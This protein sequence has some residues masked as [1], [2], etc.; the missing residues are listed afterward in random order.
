MTVI[1][2]LLITFFLLLRDPRVQTFLA[3]MASDYLSKALKTEIRIG[4]FDLSVFRGLIIEKIS[5]KDRYNQQ[6]ISADKISIIPGRFSYSKK[7]LNIQKIFLDKGVFQLVTHKGD[8][9]LSFQFIIDYFSSRTT[10]QKP[11]DTTPGTKWNLS[12][13]AVQIADTRFH[14]QDENAAPADT[15][16]DY[17]NIDINHINILIT[18]FI[19]YEDTLVGKIRYLSAVERSGFALRSFSGD[20]R[21]SSKFIRVK[22]L[23]IVTDRANLDLDL[24]F[25]Y[26]TWSDF[27][28]F[29]NKV[30]IRAE[31]NPSEIDLQ[32]I[33]HF[34][35][36]MYDMK[37]R[38][39][40]RG[41]VKGTVSNFRARDLKFAFGTHSR[42]SGN[43]TATGL[44]NVEETFV[45]MNIKS[46][47]TKQEDIESF[48]LPA[49]AGNITLPAILKSAG[50]FNLKGMFTGFYNDFV[51][52]AR[53][54]TAIGTLVTDLTLRKPKG[55][56]QISYIGQANGQQLNLGEL[57]NTK[58][59]GIVSFRAD[60]NGQGLNYKNADLTANM[61]I[62]SL[63]LNHYNYRH[64]NIKGGLAEKKFNGQLLVN[65]PNLQLDFNGLVDFSDT[66][67]L[68]DFNAHIR[69][70]QL[71]TLNILKRDSIMN[72]TTTLNVN[73]RGNNLDNIEGII[74]ID[75]TWYTEG[76][77][78]VPMQ[79]LSLLTSR[80][81]NNY[82]SYHLVSD[83]VNADISGKFNFTDL[84]PSV[85]S[86]IT[87]Y[88]ASF[89]M[90]KE[91]V[92]ALPMTNQQLHYRI[93]IKNSDPLTAVFVPF[94]KVAPNT[95]VEGDYDE[96][97][98]VIAVNGKSDKIGLFGM[99]LHNW[100]V[101]ATS[102][103]DNLN[104]ITGCSDFE[105]KKN[106][107]QD[108]LTIVMD[109]LRIV[110]N[111]REDSIHYRIT[112]NE[113][114]STSLIGG[115][116]SFR[117][118]PILDLKLTDFNV[119]IDKRFWHISPGNLI[120]IDSTG[121]SISDLSFRKEEQYLKIEGKVSSQK[122]DTLFADFNKVDISNLD[123]FIGDPSVNIDGIL[124]G[125]FSLS[126]I[127][128]KLT[129]LADLH[130]DGFSFNKEA[131][132][133]ATFRI[134]Y[135]D[136]LKRFDVNSE[137]LYTGNTGT[138]IPFKLSGSYFMG[139]KEPRM[140]FDLHL[141]NLNLKMVAPFVSS[142]MSR[143][144]GFASGDVKITGKLAEPVFKGK[145]NLM[146]TEFCIDYLK[147]PYTLADVVTVEEGYFGF[148]NITLYDSLGNKAYLNGKITHKHLR[149]VRLDLNIDLNDFSAFRNTFAQNNLFY[150]TARGT[151]NVKITGPLDDIFIGVKAQTGGGTHVIIPINTTAGVGQ[152]DYIL[153]DYRGVDTVA[154]NKIQPTISSTG[155][156]LNIALQVNPTADLEVFFPDQLGSINAKGAGNFTMTLNP[157]SDFTLG[158]TYTI[159]KGTFLFQL[160]NLMRYNLTI[161]EGSRIYWTG[162]PTDADISMSAVYKSRV[163]LEGLTT[164]ADLKSVR[165]PVEC[166]V[167]LFGKLMNPDISVSL[168]LPNVDESIKAMVFSA[169]DTTN[170]AE[171][172]QQMINILVFNQFRSTQGMNT[173]NINVGNTSL[174]LLT[175]LA[176]S[177]TSKFSKRVNIGLNYARSSTNAGQ[178]IDVAISTQ[179][180][181]E[182]LH[183]DGLFGMNSMNPNATAQKASTIVGDINIAYDLTRN[184]R[185]QLRGFNRTNT[186]DNLN[187]NNSPYTQGFGLSFKRDFNNWFDIF[188]KE[189]K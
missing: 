153:F 94:L 98:Q 64:I 160:R 69:R 27:N 79:Q 62:D 87:N 131:L 68:F 66:L 105:L 183:L 17:S 78:V 180:F 44:P 58:T 125:R 135:D 15:G 185:W 118:S 176:N 65:D 170:S 93:K 157:Y 77:H 115:Y 103:I 152:N 99:Q 18:D 159:Q 107:E 60:I 158:G 9:S 147:V 4:G 133:D 1:L 144:S 76:Q 36:V 92:A 114:D 63:E 82:K 120:Y 150:G 117:N 14:Y 112:W 59:L 130:L 3:R 123:Y 111:I 46:F 51:A 149:D 154:F 40:F 48:N 73:F 175:N 97:G 10:V 53:L 168:N 174:S 7:I 145:I 140:D 139:E 28:D 49:G 35:P 56:M 136:G 127:F 37:D 25:T 5:V 178:E 13:S 166:I 75:S 100:Y 33:G 161:K 11:V 163:P 71:F 52:N 42:F 57:F 138:N 12:F 84:I 188:K 38:I 80:D 146:R 126:N 24:E 67:P 50:T 22:Q 91:Q 31:I 122:E 81:E 121:V 70:A 189:K 141:K 119:M 156:S 134:R 113:R 83:F 179:V 54:S 128:S 177:F 88:L 43:I 32:E 89:N 137:I 45:D 21:V 124:S 171:M 116:L 86:F 184:R 165:V 181:N 167:H 106:D 55:K 16:M 2:S 41:N 108:T 110:S 34:A 109:S 74:L 61:V 90:N 102:R 172:T 173:G 155:L 96:A 30:K 8:S 101:H 162:D 186:Y 104:I 23:K 143:V 142:F 169:I 95:M 85:E 26:D 164:D 187:L 39:K 29:L 47:S 148:N 182:R 6:I 129:V 132:G 20:C 151:G 72:L 19:P